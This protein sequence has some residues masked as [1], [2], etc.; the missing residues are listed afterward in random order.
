MTAYELML[1]ESQERML[2]VANQGKENDVIRICKKWD[3][4]VAVVGRVTNDGILRVRIRASGAE[5][6][7]KAL[8]DDG[9]KYDRPNAPPAYQEYLQ[10]L[11]IVYASRR[12]GCQRPHSARFGVADDRQ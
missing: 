9:P 7:A 10:S 11:T 6:P 1:S 12:K 8:A 4:D 3:L 5:I 2:M